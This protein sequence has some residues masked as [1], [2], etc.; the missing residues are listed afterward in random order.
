MARFFSI[1][2]LFVALGIA[3]VTRPEVA[4]AISG[5]WAEFLAEAAHRIIAMWDSSTILSGTVIRDPATGFA[6]SVDTE[7]T[8]IDPIVIFWAAV[9]A[10]PTDWKHKAVGLVIG[11]VGLQ[12][13]NFVRILGL[14]FTGLWDRTVFVW[15][16]HNL[17]QG[18]IM[19]GAVL[20]FYAWLKL[21][22]NMGLARSG[23]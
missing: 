5:P 19:L 1:F 10:F 9:L 17:W 2:V 21:G 16:H 7:C 6:V 15:S 14:Y 18:V 12:S 22:S 8:G 13:L 23:N 4:S 20:L 3:L 11:L